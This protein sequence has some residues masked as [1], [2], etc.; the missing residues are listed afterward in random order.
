[1]QLQAREEEL[2]QV[3]QELK[4]LQERLTRSE[5]SWAEKG[6]EFAYQQKLLEERVGDLTK[7][8]D[9]LH[10]EA[11]KVRIILCGACSLVNAHH[12]Q[13]ACP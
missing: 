11:D 1:V 9:V 13:C 3:Q 5:G 10:D 7:Q 8:N 2:L 4:E 6:A 12:I